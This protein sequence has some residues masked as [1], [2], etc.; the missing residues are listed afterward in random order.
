MEAF[1]YE[2]FEGKREMKE[3]FATVELM[4]VQKSGDRTLIELKN[5]AYE[6]PGEL[7]FMFCA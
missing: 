1:L 7:I 5:K 6:R 3:M 2:L 4:E